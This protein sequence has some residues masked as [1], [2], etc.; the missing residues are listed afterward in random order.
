M[1]DVHLSTFLK[2]ISVCLNCKT[3]LY[4]SL[5][6]I[7]A[8]P[9]YCYHPATNPAFHETCTSWALLSSLLTQE[10]GKVCY[11]RRHSLRHH[12]LHNNAVPLH[13]HQGSNRH[14]SRQQGFGNRQPGHRPLH[15][16]PSNDCH[17][18]PTHVT[19][20]KDR[21]RSRFRI[22]STVSQI[23]YLGEKHYLTS[24]SKCLCHEHYQHRLPL[25]SNYHNH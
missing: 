19:P 10:G 4:K 24:S 18:F 25:P 5:I 15:P 1:Y 2:E 8:G 13:L 7:P 14:H 22:W 9:R 3:A 6:S 11:P 12:L 20:E 17:F 23:H 21:S 16:C